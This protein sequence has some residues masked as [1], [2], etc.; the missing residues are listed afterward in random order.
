MVEAAISE[1]LLPAVF[2]VEGITGHLRRLTTLPVRF[3]GMGLPSPSCQSQQHHETSF[4]M[5][6][7]LRDAL[8]GKCDFDIQAHRRR[9]GEV[10]RKSEEA[11]ERRYESA[12]EQELEEKSPDY[13]R[14]I[15]ERGCCTGQWLS[16]LPT[17]ENHSILAAEQFRDGLAMR[18][19]FEPLG[20]P[21]MCDG[22]NQR[23]GLRHALQCKVG[24]L[25]AQRHDEVRDE[26]VLLCK[27]AF[28]PK[29][30]RDEPRIPNTGPLR[31]EKGS[32][33]KAEEA[34]KVVKG[35]GGEDEDDVGD[36]AERGDLL[37]RGFWGRQVPCVVDV[38]VTDTDSKS[39]ISRKVE[40]VLG[41][42]E[43]EKK[44]K[45]LQK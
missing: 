5:T 9:I 18:Y 13:K 33:A 2:G 23:G 44:R 28:S 42:Q 39:A 27:Q 40:K 17:T 45:Y 31:G 43:K 7:H 29:V 22:C 1:E 34:V 8:A 25:I 35:N 3:G 38:R 36:N 15:V 20:M 11:A 10:R 14:M 41:G 16:V 12:L 30:V 24:G 4:A 37:V 21:E 19:G 32:E 6:N 26:L